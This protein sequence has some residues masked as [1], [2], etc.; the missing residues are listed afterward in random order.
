MVLLLCLLYTYFHIILFRVP[1]LNT[2]YLQNYTES[3]ERKCLNGNGVSCYY[4]P[5]VYPAICE[6]HSKAKKCYDVVIF[7]YIS[8]YAYK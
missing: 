1:P 8:S 7:L 4:V 5:T 3:G 6:I 2:Q